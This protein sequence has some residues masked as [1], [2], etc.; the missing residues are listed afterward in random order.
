M[1]AGATRVPVGTNSTSPSLGSG[2][3]D[4]SRR[5]VVVKIKIVFLFLWC[6]AIPSAGLGRGN[7]EAGGIRSARTCVNRCKSARTSSAEDKARLDLISP[8]EPSF[9][10]LKS[11]G[12]LID[13]ARETPKP[14][15]RPI[16]CQRVDPLERV[17]HRRYIP[18]ARPRPP[19]A[20]RQ[21]GAF[22]RTCSRRC[23]ARR[24]QGT[25]SYNPSSSI[26][27]DRQGSNTVLIRFDTV[28]HILC[29]RRRATRLPHFTTGA[30]FHPSHPAKES[31]RPPSPKRS[32]AGLPL[33]DGD[34]HR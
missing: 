31:R 29:S 3:P 5:I 20:S 1:R 30:T 28:A 23:H 11:S 7:G 9:G 4:R 16:T 33:R 12:M 6:A 26:S 24:E 18:T 34:G 2:H 15:P 10:E 21:Q 25:A 32:S 27:S 22:R 17:S 19:E 13:R 14:P 8:I